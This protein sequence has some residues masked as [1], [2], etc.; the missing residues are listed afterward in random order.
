MIFHLAT[1]E[2]VPGSVAAVLGA[3]EKALARRKAASL[4]GCWVAEVGLLNEI[5]VLRSFRSAEAM[6][7]EPLGGAELRFPADAATK[8]VAVQQDAYASFP[9]IEP[10]VKGELGRFYEIRTYHL[11]ED[12]ESLPASIA[13]WQAAV[14][15]RISLS[16]L[17]IVMHALAEPKR[18]VHIWPYTSLDQR[19]AVRADA[20]AKGWWPPR[21]SLQ[22]MKRAQ[23]AIYVPAP[24]SPLQ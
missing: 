17:V 22:W 18:I 1:I 12:P 3:L 19:Q 5:A 8:V 21:G 2:C 7:A 23:T 6:E 13:S 4:I 16:P 15:D 10:V 9:G 11:N 20:L 24:F 14:P